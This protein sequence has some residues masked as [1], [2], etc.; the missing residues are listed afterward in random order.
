[1]KRLIILI[2]LFPLYL[3][4][5]SLEEAITAA[6]ENNHGLNQEK[7]EIEVYNQKYYAARGMLL[8]QLTLQGQYSLSRTELPESSQSEL[9]NLTDMLDD[10]MGTMSSTDEVL[11]DNQQLIT[12]YLDGMVSSL[13][14]GS[15]IKEGSFAGGL[16]ISQVLFAGGKLISGIKIADRVRNI[17]KEN[18]R[19][20]V[21]EVIYETTRL[22]YGVKLAHEVWQ[23]QNDALELTDEHLQDVDKMYQQG[24]V[25]EYDKLRAE[26][27]YKKMEPEVLQAG[28]D[29]NL[30]RENFCNYI[31]YTGDTDFELETDFNLPEQEELVLE[32]ALDEGMSNRIEVQLSELNVRIKEVL[33]KMEKADFYPVIALTASYNFYTATDDYEIEGDDFGTQASVGLGFQL[34]LFTGLTR[35]SEVR[36]AQA[37]II[38]A[39]EADAD[40][41]EMIR[42]DIRNA[43]QNLDHSREKLTVQ[44]NNSALA[45]RGYEIAQSRYANGQG[46]ELEIADAQLNRQQAKLSYSN[47][48]YE[49]ILAKIY[50]DKAIGR[51]LDKM[52]KEK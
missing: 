1:M 51:D 37:E 50:F 40:I 29:L 42:L 23:I 5:M 44:E 41:Q 46:T 48:L 13:I 19:L 3:M 17:Q 47:A 22:Y 12:G 31:G 9:D 6:L 26:L 20:K 25:S 24:L 35:I 43:W 38:K 33:A 11:W 32:T 10:E 8:P 2:L 30:G 36:E 15:V 27:E 16:E 52:R 21:Q 39:E 28:Y 34:P 14:P 4:S 45:E 49:V 7:Q 18:Y